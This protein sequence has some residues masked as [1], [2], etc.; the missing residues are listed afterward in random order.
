M[1]KITPVPTSTLADTALIKAQ[2][3]RGTIYFREWS[4]KRSIGKN[5]PCSICKKKDIFMRQTILFSNILLEE[6][7]H[8]RC[9]HVLPFRYLFVSH[10][11]QHCLPAC[12]H[13]FK[14]LSISPPFS[15][16]RC[17]IAM[18]GRHSHTS[19]SNER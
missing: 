4:P 7:P 2:Y 11:R 1:G 5:L 19:P 13:K 9:S 17:F 3:F 18:Q 6:T 10:P 8:V 14:D 16:L 12:G 15:P